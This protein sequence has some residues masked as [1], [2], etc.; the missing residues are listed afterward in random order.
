MQ[1]HDT[2]KLNLFFNTLLTNPYSAAVVNES[3]S[4][5]AWRQCHHDSVG[6]RPDRMVRVTWKRATIFDI[7]LGLLECDREVIGIFPRAASL[8]KQI[9]NAYPYLQMKQN[10][11]TYGTCA[12]PRPRMKQGFCFTNLCMCVIYRYRFP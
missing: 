4:W 12:Y 11:K 9:F 8:V 10:E 2:Y 7:V 5:R 6:T 1:S 3:H